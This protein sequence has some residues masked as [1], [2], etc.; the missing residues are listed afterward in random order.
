MQLGK[1]KTSSEV[2]ICDEETIDYKGHFLQFTYNLLAGVSPFYL[3][4]SLFL[5]VGK[6]QQTTLPPSRVLVISIFFS[7]VGQEMEAYP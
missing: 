3:V 1:G 4:C 6:S 7:L 2:P 5:K